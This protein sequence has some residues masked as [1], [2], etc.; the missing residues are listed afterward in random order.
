MTVLA[1]PAAG[2]EYVVDDVGEFWNVIYDTPLYSG[3]I[4]TITND[5]IWADAIIINDISITFNLINDANLT[6]ET[7]SSNG[8]AVYTGGE[9]LLTG[10]GDFNIISESSHSTGVFADSGCSATV[11]NVTAIGEAS[12]GTFA[13][14]G[15]SI[16]VLNNVFSSGLESYATQAVDGG[17]ITVGGIAMADGGGCTGAYAFEGKIFIGGNVEVSGTTCSAV[18]VGDNGE[19]TVGGDVTATGDACKGVISTSSGSNSSA[20]VEGNITASGKDCFGVTAEFGDSSIL[21]GGTVNASGENCRGVNAIDG[22]ATVNGSA[23]INGNNSYAVYADGTSMIHV[24]QNAVASGSGVYALYVNAGSEVSVGRDVNVFA[25]GILQSYGVY[26]Y[27]GTTAIGGDIVGSGNGIICAYADY[28]GTLTVS[29]SA[30]SEGHNSRGAIAR[31]A[32]SSVTIEQ[33][34]TATG[35]YCYGAFASENGRITVNGSITAG[36][37]AITDT[38]VSGARAETGGMVTVNGN[39]SAIGSQSQGAFASDPGSYV[40]IGQ[41][42]M[43]TGEYCHG[44]SL[45]GGGAATVNGN[46]AINSDYGI[47]AN[48]YINSSVIVN[49]N[50]VANGID[51]CGVVADHSSTATVGGIITSSGTNNRGVS[52]D[53]GSVITV[54]GSVN[55]SYPIILN[56][57]NLDTFTPT[58]IGIYLVYK[59]S[60]KMATIRI[61]LPLMPIINTNPVDITKMENE[62]AVFTI[63]ATVSDGGTLHYQWQKSTNGGSTWNNIPS[64]TNTS[65]TT[66]ALSAGDNGNQYKCSVRN[67]KNG[68][69]SPYAYSNSA[70]LTVNPLNTLISISTPSAITGLT[71]GTVKTAAALGLPTEA[72]MVTNGGNMSASINWDV[73]SCAYNAASTGAQTFEVTGSAILPTGVVNT[74]SVSL[75]ISISVSVMGKAT[76]SSGKSSPKSESKANIV[77]MDMA[78]L[79]AAFNKAEATRDGVK[80]I[81]IQIPEIKNVKQYALELPASILNA[82]EEE[83][84]IEMTG[85]I[86][87]ITLPD[88][89]LRG[90]GIDNAE[91]VR[92]SL[93]EGDTSGLS[94]ELQERIGSKPVI[95]LKLTAGNKAVEWNNPDAPVT[96]AVPYI[97]TAEELQDPEHIV[98]WYIDGKGNLVEIPSGRYDAKTGRVLFNITHF[99]Q[100]AIAYVTKTF[101]DLGNSA[102]ARKPIEILAS[103]GIVAGIS[104]REYAPKSKITR[105]DFLCFLIRA[106]NIE[107]NF[108]GNFDDVGSDAYYYKEIGAAKKLGI[109][110]GTGKNRF[111]P[112]AEISRQD[113]MVLTGRTLIMLDKINQEKEGPSL[114]RFTDSS[115]IA[116]YAKDSIESLVREGLITGSGSR[117][118]PRANTTRAEAAAFLYKIYEKYNQPVQ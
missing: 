74:N 107:T 12:C 25:T 115:K 45:I 87:S 100:Y 60:S 47:G 37:I 86:G 1:D 103:K 51:S 7:N 54:D 53:N 27:G 59:Q 14:G 75:T 99:S 4:I 111:Y 97:P 32:G 76:S 66:A 83:K 109:T 90:A 106:L 44:V 65:Y 56:G 24:G 38:G 28:G 6:I 118:N 3:D 2:T 15:G 43:A 26:E 36:A 64:A 71:N 117:L 108:E 69:Y 20:I 31:D 48:M 79:N 55:A 18:R 85:K 22:D 95:E 113:M 78:A 10:T 73:A 29:G 39:A 81:T 5:I 80:H 105:G 9:V 23:S 33:N 84:R 50:I 16:T 63:A 91:K 34:V 13:Y 11:T 110:A 49:G 42:V 40:V 98:I 61:R 93:G 102:W 112:D 41:S 62:Q 116:V 52:A 72:T 88:D 68:T 46:I 57:L 67:Y 35:N 30:I 92:I 77:I 114:V 96:V 82:E 70:T 21:V 58:V 17:N 19:I 8:L 94:Q 89:M 101:D 104:E